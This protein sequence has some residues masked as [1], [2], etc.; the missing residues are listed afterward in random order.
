VSGGSPASQIWLASSMPQESERLH[1]PRPKEGSSV[2]EETC[3]VG[4]AGPRVGKYVHCRSGSSDSRLQAERQDPIQPVR[5]GSRRICAHGVLD[6]LRWRDLLGPALAF[7][8]LAANDPGDAGRCGWR[9]GVRVCGC[10]ET[11]DGRRRVCRP[12][13]TR[14]VSDRFRGIMLETPGD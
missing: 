3:K 5:D 4:L 6:L 8:G 2:R 10:D 9:E 14:P 13:R 12:L 11:C 1:R 7:T